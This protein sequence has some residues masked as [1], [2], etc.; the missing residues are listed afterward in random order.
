[1]IFQM[2]LL[3]N[4]RVITMILLPTSKKMCQIS[5]KGCYAQTAHLILHKLYNYTSVPGAYEYDYNQNNNIIHMHLHQLLP[6]LLN[7]PGP[8]PAHL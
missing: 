5:L 3:L 8:Q 2:V 6:R 7:Y 4:H 1:M